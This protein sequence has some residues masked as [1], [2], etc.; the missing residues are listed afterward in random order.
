MTPKIVQTT[1]GT[2]ILIHG[3]LFMIGAGDLA[4]TGVPN[5]SEAAFAMGKGAHE[6]VA[7][8]NVFLALVLFSARNLVGEAA[9]QVLKG[10]T[11]GLAALTAGVIY[12]SQSL[13]T[14]M[15]PPVPAIAI[16]V[17]LTS[18]SGY[19]AWRKKADAVNK[20]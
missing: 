12:H 11:F 5:I 17:L 16:F 19:V 9:T 13:P 2:L 10:T 4:K 1:I 15:A 18:W 6:I 14:E 20:K 7:M 8:F 3:I